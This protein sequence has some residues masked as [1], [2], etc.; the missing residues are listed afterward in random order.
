MR[1]NGGSTIFDPKAVVSTLK[2]EPDSI[3]V[4]A[5]SELLVNVSSVYQ[6][7]QWADML[8]ILATASYTCVIL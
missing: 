5:Q 7:V 4:V 8:T 1:I 6:P 3:I 2:H